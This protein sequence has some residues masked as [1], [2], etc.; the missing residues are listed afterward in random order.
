MSKN[1][2][3]EMLGVADA[4]QEAFVNQL[5]QLISLEKVTYISDD[6]E[7]AAN[8]LYYFQDFIQKWCPAFLDPTLSPEWES[9]L[10]PTEKSASACALEKR[11]RE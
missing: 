2:L 5:M 3:F 1:P 4:R 7:H 8:F 9:K 11:K 10:L 6:Q